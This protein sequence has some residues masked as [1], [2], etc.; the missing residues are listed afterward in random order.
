MYFTRKEIAKIKKKAFKKG[1]IDQ[2]ERG[3]PYTDKKYFVSRLQRLTGE[4][5]GEVEQYLDRS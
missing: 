4:P 2:L 5:V 1:Q 3:M